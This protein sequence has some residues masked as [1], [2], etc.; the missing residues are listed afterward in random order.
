MCLLLNSGFQSGFLVGFV[1]ST[2][3][4]ASVKTNGVSGAVP[5]VRMTGRSMS[6]VAHH[7]SRAFTE[8]GTCK[9][10][11]IRSSTIERHARFHLYIQRGERSS[12]LTLM[13]NLYRKHV[14][15]FYYL[16]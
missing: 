7:A 1:N 4:V 2:P 12:S 5:I 16:L 9:F 11:D 14:P 8:E 15:L 10:H 3:L 6:L 13:S